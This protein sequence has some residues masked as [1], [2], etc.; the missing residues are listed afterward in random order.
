MEFL[1][2]VFTAGVAGVT[3]PA[4]LSRPEPRRI[5]QVTE[6]EPQRC[7]DLLEIVDREVPFSS[8]DGPDVRAME[9]APLGECLLRETLGLPK[10]TDSFSQPPPKLDHRQ[11][12]KV[13]KR[14]SPCRQTG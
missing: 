8:L 1:R 11:H 13:R 14:M 5:Q 7:R 10:P 3:C 4:P 9:V 6:T 12:R 2:L